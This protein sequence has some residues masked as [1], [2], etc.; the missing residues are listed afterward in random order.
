MGIRNSETE[1]HLV[2]IS[3][4]CNNEEKYFQ[5]LVSLGEDEEEQLFAFTK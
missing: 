5:H 4:F 1:I 3:T 2:H